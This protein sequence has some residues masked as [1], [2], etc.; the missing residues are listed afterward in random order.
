MATPY[1][2]NGK[3]FEEQYPMEAAELRVERQQFLSRGVQA[4]EME[5]STAD[6]EALNDAKNTVTKERSDGSFDARPERLSELAEQA[7]AAG[8]DKTA[9][10]WESQISETAFMKN[11]T[12]VKEQYEVQIQAGVIP[13]DE[14]I[15]QNPALSQK[16]KQALLSKGK[17]SASGGPSPTTELAKG[18]KKIIESS[19]RER[20][21]WTRD[22]ANDPGVDAME[23]KAWQEYTATYNRELAK[24]GD[25]ATAAQEALNEFNK[26]FADKDNGEYAIGSAKNL[27]PGDTSNIGK[28]LG[29]DRSGNAPVPTNAMT[30]IRKKVTESGGDYNGVL[31][32][33]GELYDG[34]A[35]SLEALSKSFTTTGSVG[36]IPPVY[37]QLQQMSGGRS[38]IFDMLNTRLKAN[39][40]DELP[41]E[42]N[43]VIKP[44]EET[45]DEETYKYINYKPN[46]TR[47]DIG[48]I[49]SGEEPVYRSS[50]PT[51]VA[52]DTA[53][54]EEVSAVAGRLGISEA[55]LYAVMSFETGGTF[56]PG[57]RNAAGSGAT[58]LIQF[59]PSTARGLGTTT[60]ALAGMSRVEQLQYVEKYL[61]NKGIRGGNLS[62][63]YMSVLFPAAVGKP[64]NYVLFGRGAMSGYTGVAYT[65]NKGLDSNGDGSVTKAEASA[66][67]LRHRHAQPWRRPNNM[68]PELQ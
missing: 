45:F 7:R 40:L 33:K 27:K 52:S 47:T 9:D 5:R 66:K 55:D 13:A 61:S 21:K 62:D 63:V 49:N 39:G 11:S 65:Q 2:P 24:H 58:G 50:L 56:N 68:R 38:S 32:G 41:K 14:E 4:D 15:L 3:S 57:I 23:L 19:I 16:D 59:M 42:L 25:A 46:T 18:H 1:G 48:L 54:Q 34:E 28:Y 12:K 36:T 44:V 20:G 37:Y 53:F 8:L 22:G 35:T 43:N 29:Y 67:V 6:R 17:S 51:S 30:D 64:D 60:E 10:Y 31:N 26:K